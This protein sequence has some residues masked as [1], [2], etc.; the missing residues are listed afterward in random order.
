[1]ELNIEASPTKPIT[2]NGKKLELTMPTVGQV[3]D[4]QDGVKQGKSEVEL[5]IDL[6]V[7]CGIPKETARKLDL[8]QFQKIIEY[9]TSAPEKK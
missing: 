1:M 3:E 7:S 9:V 6:L 8:L 4:F 2:I 5:S